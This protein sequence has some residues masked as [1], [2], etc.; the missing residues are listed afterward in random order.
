MDISN[1]NAV[2][3]AF[4]TQAARV[5]VFLLCKEGANPI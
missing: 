1:S 2:F 3:A 5:A 4:P